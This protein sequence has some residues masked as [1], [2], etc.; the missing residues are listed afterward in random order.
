M[1]W[2]CGVTSLQE[3]KGL[4]VLEECFGSPGSGFSGTRDSV[5]TH[6]SAPVALRTSSTYMHI[7]RARETSSEGVNRWLFPLSFSCGKEAQPFQPW[8]YAIWF[9]LCPALAA[10]GRLT[11]MWVSDLFLSSSDLNFIFLQC[12]GTPKPNWSNSLKPIWTVIEE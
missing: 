3:R 1:F 9:F 6:C 2:A 5:V 7:Q 4:C 10:A 12:F 11:Q 8:S